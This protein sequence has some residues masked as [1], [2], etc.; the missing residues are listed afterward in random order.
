MKEQ[1]RGY[2]QRVKDWWNGE[3]DPYTKQARKTSRKNAKAIKELDTRMDKYYELAEEKAKQSENASKQIIQ[4][5]ETLVKEN[6]EEKAAAPVEEEKSPVDY[7]KNR[8]SEY[9]R[10]VHSVTNP[11]MIPGI[12]QEAINNGHEED[13]VR[14]MQGIRTSTYTL[15][16]KLEQ[17]IQECKYACNLAEKK[18]EAIVREMEKPENEYRELKRLKNLSDIEDAKAKRY[19][20]AM[21]SL[22]YELRI[23]EAKLGNLETGLDTVALSKFKTEINGKEIADLTR[24]LIDVYSRLNGVVEGVLGSDEELIVDPIEDPTD[25]IRSFDA[26]VASQWKTESMSDRQKEAIIKNYENRNEEL[27][28]ELKKTVATPAGLPP[29]AGTA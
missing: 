2:I 9:E 21:D 17:K 19:E 16:K 3:P 20:K 4:T 26:E 8:V 14:Y 15:K 25:A 13:V 22:S 11:D 1:K 23:A 10:G 27:P 24:G 28:E 7:F 5:L 6:E 12:V 29:A 18:S